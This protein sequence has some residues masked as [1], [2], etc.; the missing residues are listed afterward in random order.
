MTAVAAKADTIEL[1]AFSRPWWALWLH[2]VRV[3]VDV[4]PM[5]HAAR[6]GRPWRIA[7]ADAVGDVG[8]AAVNV[9]SVDFYMWQV[10]FEQ[11]GV[12]LPRPSRSPVVFLPPNAPAADFSRV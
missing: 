8:L 3:G 9:S 5:V 10:S 6:S 7:K 4:A 12:R 1:R 2:R 11:R